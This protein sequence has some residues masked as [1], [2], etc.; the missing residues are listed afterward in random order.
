LLAGGGLLNRWLDI[1]ILAGFCLL[2]FEW[3]VIIFKKRSQE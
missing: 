2:L 1:L 3:G